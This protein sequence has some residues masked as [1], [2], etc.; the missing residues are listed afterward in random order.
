MLAAWPS[1]APCVEPTALDFS[2]P[3]V[4]YTLDKFD[5]APFLK[6]PEAKPFDQIDV[7][8][9]QLRLDTTRYPVDFVP[10]A[11]NDV[12]D[13]SDAITPPPNR[14]KKHSRSSQQYFG[15]TFTTPT[16]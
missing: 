14:G 1:G 6:T 9:S 13:L 12:S 4:N 16:D 2:L 15:L 11:S 5:A 10:R 8:H 3:Q 7:G